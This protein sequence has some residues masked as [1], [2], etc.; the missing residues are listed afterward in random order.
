MQQVIGLSANGRPAGHFR[1]TA[2][3]INESRTHFDAAHDAG[4][5]AVYGRSMQGRNVAL[6]TGPVEDRPEAVDF[7]R[8]SYLGLDNH[9]VIVAGAIRGNGAPRT[10]HMCRWRTPRQ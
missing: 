7:V 2:Y 1:N 3:V 4:L 5:M 10:L 9:P 8:C 6:G